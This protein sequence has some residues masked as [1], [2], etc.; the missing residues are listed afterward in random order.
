MRKHS[1][2]NALEDAL[3]LQ[4]NAD[5]SYADMEFAILVKGRT[6]GLQTAI[7]AV[8]AMRK[9]TFIHFRRWTS[10]KSTGDAVSSYAAM[11]HSEGWTLEVGRLWLTRV[12]FPLAKWYLTR[13]KT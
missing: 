12:R 2:L 4:R 3:A 8:K 5:M 13:R 9:E 10:G 11:G 7:E 6:E 1:V